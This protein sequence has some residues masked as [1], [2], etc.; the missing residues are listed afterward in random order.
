MKPV[1]PLMVFSAIVLGG[2]ASMPSGPRVTVLPGTEKSFDEFLESDHVCRQYAQRVIGQTSSDPAVRDAIVGT[3]VGT[4]AGAAIGG[5]QGAGVGAGVGL[6]FGSAAGAESNRLYGY[7][8]QYRYD[9]AYMQ[10]MYAAGHRIPVP[11]EVAKA[12]MQRPAAVV[13]EGAGSAVDIPPP[14]PHLPPLSPPSDY[15]RPR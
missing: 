4:A 10:C 3:A 6:I 14:P 13:P 7:E 12:L 5:S 11:A 2:C 1:L 15:V 8:A 9:E